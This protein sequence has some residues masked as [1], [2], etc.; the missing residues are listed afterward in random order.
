MSATLLA[1][2]L[3]TLV[4]TSWLARPRDVARSRESR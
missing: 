4:V 2:S 1:I 3:A